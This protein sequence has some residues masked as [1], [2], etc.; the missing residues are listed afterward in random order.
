MGYIKKIKGNKNFGL[1]TDFSNE[2]E[3]YNLKYNLQIGKPELKDLFKDFDHDL[4]LL[5]T[6]NSV[7]LVLEEDIE[8]YSTKAIKALTLDL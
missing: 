2:A 7:E 8:K 1:F 5:N 3:V 6:L 4:N